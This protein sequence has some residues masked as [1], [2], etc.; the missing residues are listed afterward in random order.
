M[1][2]DFINFFSDDIYAYLRD[3]IWEI[4][5]SLKNKYRKNQEI[6]ILDEWL[7]FLFVIGLFLHFVKSLNNEK[8]V[9]LKDIVSNFKEWISKESIEE[10]CNEFI[11]LFKSKEIA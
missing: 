7:I 3:D 8:A 4:Y 5:C 2:D 1:G 6:D 9:I 10:R 11:R